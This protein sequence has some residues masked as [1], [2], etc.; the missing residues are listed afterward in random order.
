MKFITISVV[1]LGLGSNVLAA[2]TSLISDERLSLVNC[3]RNDG[4][5]DS[6][7]DCEDCAI[8]SNNDIDE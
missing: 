5:S 6:R 4:S 8:H 7:Y 1:A 3:E 2:P